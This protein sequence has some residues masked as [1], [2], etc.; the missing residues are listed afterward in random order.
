MRRRKHK[1]NQHGAIRTLPKFLILLP[2]GSDPTTIQ[3]ALS[4]EENQN[5]TEILIK[6][7][8]EETGRWVKN[9]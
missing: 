2:S 3:F 1:R 8:N 7:K 4:L 6:I 9:G 5:L